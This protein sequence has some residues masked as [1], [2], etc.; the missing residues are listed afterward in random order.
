MENISSTAELQDAIQLLE[1]EQDVKLMLVKYHFR[2]AYDSLKPI[3]II[4]NI[5]DE[6][7]TS[8]LLPNNVIDIAI[9]LTAGYVSRKAVVKKSDGVLKKLFGVVLQF[10]VTKLVAQN[11]ETIKSYGKY[12]LQHIFSKKETNYNKP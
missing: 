6:I 3:N 4:G 12:I 7:T 5:L 2:Q 10:G 8:H 9:G 1:A 11:P